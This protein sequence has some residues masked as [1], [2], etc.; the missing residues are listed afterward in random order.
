[1]FDAVRELS[2][3]LG[4][5]TEVVER[6]SKTLADNLKVLED[7]LPIRERVEALELSRAMHQAEME[8]L[9]LKADALKKVARNAEERTRT[10]AA[11]TSEA[12]GGDSDGE[13]ELLEAIEAYRLSH[14]DVEAGEAAEVPALHSGMEVGSKEAAMMAKF[15]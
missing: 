14:R 11:K 15:G 13:A 5:L 2:E 10:L 7:G 1:M 12:D 3:S 9:V 4:P 8:A 6:L